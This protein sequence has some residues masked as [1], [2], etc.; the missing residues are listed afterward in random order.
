VTPEP[1]ALGELIY[2]ERVKRRLSQDELATATG[3]SRPTI[4]LW[5]RGGR[6]PK[7]V[8]MVP[9]L[10]KVFRVTRHLGIPDER[11]IRAVQRL[12]VQAARE[13]DQQ[14]AEQ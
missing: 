13:T 5:E 12:Q 1:T 11:V 7:G 8:I 4:S 2:Q 14:D 3:V 9:T 6:N 10:T